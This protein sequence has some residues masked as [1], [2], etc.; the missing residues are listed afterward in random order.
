MHTTKLPINERLTR[1]GQAIENHLNY[2]ARFFSDVSERSYS[3]CYRHG[4]Y[5]AI[6]N[7][8][9][10]EAGIREPANGV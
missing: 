2:K 3:S 5:K 7:S 10:A 1:G 9:G 6:V 8:T 4:I